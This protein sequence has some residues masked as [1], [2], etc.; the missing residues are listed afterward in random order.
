VHPPGDLFLSPLQ[1]VDGIALQ[2]REGDIEVFQDTTLLEM[3][4]V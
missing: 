3:R 1:V 2:S 4:T